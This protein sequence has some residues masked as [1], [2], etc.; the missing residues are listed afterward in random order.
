MTTFSPFSRPLY[1]MAKPAGP[2][3]NLACEYCYYLEKSRL[4]PDDSN[5]ILSDELLELFIRQ[6]LEAQTTPEVLFT[7]HGGE[8]LMRPISFYRKA[9]QLQAKYARGRR[10]SNSI[11]TNGTLL[12]DDWCR[13]LRDNRFLVGL[14]VDGPADFHNEYRRDRQGRPS[15]YKVMKG[16]ELLK[17]HGV[18]YNAMAVVNDYNADFPLEFY[19]F[20]KSIGCR[21]IQF[22]PIVER[23]G[24]HADGTR[25]ASPGE[26]TPTLA[27]FSITPRQWG[28]FLCAIF[29]E[30][31]QHDVSHYYIQLFD[32]TLANWF[33]IAPGLCSV[34][35]TCGHAGVMEYNGDVYSCDHFVF[36]EY[37]LGNIRSESL[38]TMMYS[39]R[40]RTFGE[41]KKT[42]LPRQCRECEFL[43]AC[44]G[45]CP[46]NRFLA[47]ADGEPGLN[48]LCEGYL[49]FFHHVAPFMDF[50][51]KELEAKRPPA[52]IMQHVREENG[53]V[54][55]ISEV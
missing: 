41:A 31:V 50:M 48:Y 9:L 7:W 24:S 10:I 39:E 32:A 12:N 27:P 47:T 25:L 37:R 54:R 46:K 4:Y 33:G 36:P 21:Y 28:D 20:F 52:N 34:A 2:L 53:E 30:W 49:R 26:Q 17:K 45:E 38:T 44:H 22:T 29:D 13:F 14:S 1:V 18:E 51:K 55:L 16:I 3:C 43:F 42:A 23:L 11:Q 35:E 5:R 40:Q 8:P 15:F 19:R 6:Y